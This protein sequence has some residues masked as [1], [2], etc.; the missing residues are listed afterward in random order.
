MINQI[1]LWRFQICIAMAF[2]ALLQGG[3][4]SLPA[5]LVFVHQR[6][7]RIHPSWQIATGTTIRSLAFHPDSKRLV[8]GTNNASLEIW[9]I[10]NKSSDKVFTADAQCVS[11]VAVSPDGNFVAAGSLDRLG[12]TG[13]I[14]V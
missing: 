5:P 7:T 6:A 3:C 4:A 13:T 11:A 2:S 14:Y 12:D 8:G 9:T 10:G 1:F